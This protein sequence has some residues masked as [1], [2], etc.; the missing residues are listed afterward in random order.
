MTVTGCS[1][2]ECL[3]QRAVSDNHIGLDVTPFD[4]FKQWLYVTIHMVQTP[5]RLAMRADEVSTSNI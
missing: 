5:T 1:P 2:L 3:D 4:T